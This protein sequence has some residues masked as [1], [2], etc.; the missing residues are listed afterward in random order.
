[1]GWMI[2]EPNSIIFLNVSLGRLGD[3]LRNMRMYAFLIIR[4]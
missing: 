2:V 3:W 1:M 4:E